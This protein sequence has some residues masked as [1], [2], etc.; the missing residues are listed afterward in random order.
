MVCC[1]ERSSEHF[2]DISLDLQKGIS[3]LY[4]S[5]YYYYYY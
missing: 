5:Y 3:V 1:M 2:L 4:P